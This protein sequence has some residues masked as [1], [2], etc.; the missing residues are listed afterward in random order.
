MHTGEFV[1]VLKY[2]N[3]LPEKVTERR[4]AEAL[5]PESAVGIDYKTFCARF[6]ERLLS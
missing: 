3:V 6:R 2:L 5:D 4:V 1:K